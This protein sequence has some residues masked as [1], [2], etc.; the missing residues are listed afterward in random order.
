MRDRLGAP[1]LLPGAQ[2]TLDRHLTPG[3][4]PA[5]MGFAVPGDLTSIGGSATTAFLGRLRR[6][7]TTAGD[8]VF[9]YRATARRRH[10]P[11]REVAAVTVT[12][13]QPR[14]GSTTISLIVAEPPAPP[15]EISEIQG[16]RTSRRRSARPSTTRGIVIGKI[17]TS[18]YIQDPIR[19][20]NA[21][22]S[23]GLSLRCDSDGRRLGR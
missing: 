12:D 3:A 5:S 2:S 18:F 13:A 11:R 7:D 22:T 10:D 19:T 4:N 1:G 14:S 23:E 17:G 20:G 9:M 8:N 15:I 16:A 21:A 6:P